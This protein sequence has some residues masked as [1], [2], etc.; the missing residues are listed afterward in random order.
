LEIVENLR[1]GNNRGQ[2][3]QRF[4]QVTRGFSS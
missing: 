4:C 1:R 2:A 3:A